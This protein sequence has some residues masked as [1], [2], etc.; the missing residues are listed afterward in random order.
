V[1]KSCE[2]KVVKHY[3]FV[4]SMS[5]STA[6]QGSFNFVAME[7]PSFALVRCL[8]CDRVSAL[9]TTFFVECAGLEL[10]MDVCGFCFQPVPGWDE[11]AEAAEDLIRAR[12]Q[13]IAITF[14]QNTP[15]MQSFVT[16]EPATEDEST[17]VPDD[18]VSE[19][20]DE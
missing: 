6:K 18:E 15:W 19:L 11:E 9:P 12:L 13:L 17:A 3:V 16:A 2:E 14:L 1:P 10:R 5:S 20:S 7:T 4:T 8:L